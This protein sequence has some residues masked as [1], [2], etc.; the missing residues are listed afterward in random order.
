MKTKIKFLITISIF[1]LFT[2]VALAQTTPVLNSDIA[3]EQN[4]QNQAFIDASGLQPVSPTIIITYVIKLVLSFLGIIFFLLILY[5]GFMWMTSAGNDEKISKAKKIMM[6]AFIGL[7]IVLSAYA[8]TIFVL[9][10][11]LDIDGS[12]NVSTYQD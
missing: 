7:V 6:A 11:I 12:G 3:A 2:S 9:E 10:R 8:I 1:L 5:A 4:T